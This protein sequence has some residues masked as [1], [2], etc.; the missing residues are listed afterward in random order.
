VLIFLLDATLIPYKENKKEDY[1]VLINELSGYDAKLL[2]K[3]RI[4]CFTKTDALTDEQ[5]KE[6]NK[7][8]FSGTGKKKK[9]DGNKIPVV[10]ISA[11]SGENIKKLLDETW[12]L[13]NQ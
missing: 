10:K 11:I 8:K 7:I 12:M 2:E 1:E 13:I 3:P 9:E 4:I 5:K 6:L